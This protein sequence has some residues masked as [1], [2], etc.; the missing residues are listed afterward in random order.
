MSTEIVKQQPERLNLEAIDS[1]LK[2]VEM[3]WT[4]ID[5]ELDL[6]GIGRKDTPFTAPIRM[7]LIA[8]WI[9]V[10]HG[11][12]PFILSVEQAFSGFNRPRSM[13]HR[14]LPPGSTPF[15]K[16]GDVASEYML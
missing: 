15:R 7:R 9:T 11:F 14:F 16:S 4:Q 5:D 2:T 3:H 12:P 13:L 8:N 6:R 10:Y 1:S